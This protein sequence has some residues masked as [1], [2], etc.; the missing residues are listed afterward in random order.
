MVGFEQ[1]HDT[2][3]FLQPL[4]E[5]GTHPSLPAN[6][7]RHRSDDL[8]GKRLGVAAGHQ[9]AGRRHRAGQ[10]NRFVTTVFG[11]F[12]RHQQLG[13]PLPLRTLLVSV[14]VCAAEVEHRLQPGPPNHRRTFPQRGNPGLVIRGRP[15]HPK[16]LIVERVGLGDL[17]K[18][19]DAVGL[20][21]HLPQQ[22]EVRRWMA[23]RLASREPV[24]AAGHHSLPRPCH[25]HVAQA[26]L[27]LPRGDHEF[28]LV[29]GEVLAPAHCAQLRHPLG[30][31]PQRGWQHLRL[32]HPVV[33]RQRAGEDTFAQR[34]QED[35]V[36]LESLGAMGGEQLHRIEA[37]RHRP[38]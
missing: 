8:G 19:P 14:E 16:L 33:R 1:G 28:A 27:G 37:A 3:P 10:R 21:C 24:V 30:I 13:G 2:E 15:G 29:V 18:L 5:A 32:G 22:L 25:R 31:A 7:P 11:P 38:V 26:V 34:G 4:V 6:R 36:P 17:C 35:Q 9:Q 23:R 20:G 12:L